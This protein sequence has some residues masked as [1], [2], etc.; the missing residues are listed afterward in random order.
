MSVALALA[1]AGVLIFF[2]HHAAEI[3]QTRSV[4]AKVNNDLH[5]LIHRVFPPESKDYSSSNTSGN[6]LENFESGGSP[7]TTASSGYLQAIDRGNLVK[8]AAE[9]GLIL[10]SQ[11]QPGKFVFEGSPLVLV[12]P[13]E[14]LDDQLA[15]KIRNRFILGDQRTYE[16]D[17]E[18][19]LDQL[20]EIAVRS[21]PWN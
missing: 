5:T 17:V 4:I 1:G 20:V 19:A 10:Y 9:C 2:I 8:L 12:W 18:F 16:Q 11:Y 15:R 7:V 6:T 13:E 14:K 3:I 21:L